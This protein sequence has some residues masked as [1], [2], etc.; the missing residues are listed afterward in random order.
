[1]PRLFVFLLW[2]VLAGS[3]S[4]QA[5][6]F[7]DVSNVAV[8]RYA[9]P[10]EPTKD[11]RVWGAVRTA[12]IY[13]VESDAT[14]LDVLT[15]AG[16][17]AIPTTSDRVEQTVRVEVLRNPNGARSVVLATTLDALTDEDV[18]LPDLRDGDLVSL[19]SETR[20]RFTWRD[21]ISVASSAASIALLVIRITE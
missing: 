10:G 15:L 11:I 19:T 2:T 7:T 9:A 3:V 13:Q 17:P 14:L 5:Q 20:Q 16:G 21:V 6:G 1:M 4:V 18:T 12:G 8:F